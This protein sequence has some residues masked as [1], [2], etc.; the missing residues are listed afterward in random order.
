MRILLLLL[1]L[2]Q[3]GQALA[4]AALLETSPEDGVAL[5]AAPD[6]VRLRFDEPVGLIALG[7][8]GPQ[9]A[10]A[11]A[12][13]RG[14][15]D[16]LTARLPPGLPRGTY[17]LSWRV[18]SVDSHPVAGT[19]AFGIG[20]AP[21]AGHAGGAMPQAFWLLPSMGLRTLFLATLLVA[22]GGALFRLVTEPPAAIR[23]GLAWLAWAGVGL[24]GLQIGVR[25]ALLADAPDLMASAPWTLGAGTTL[26]LSLGVSAAGLAGCALSARAPPGWG[27]AAAL[28]ALAGLPLSGHA[29]TADPR[30][31]TAPALLLHAL[32]AALWLGAFW[33]LLGVLRG[34]G[35]VSALRRFSAM[36]VPAVAVLLLSGL[37]LAVVQVGSM[38][39][40]SDSAYG[41]WLQM[42]ATLVSVL[43][44]LAAWNKLVATPALEAGGPPHVLRRSIAI[45]AALGL[46]VL[47]V[48]AVLG[49]TP[50]PRA[51]PR[52]TD[53][54]LWTQA[55]G[56]G[57]LIE[58]APARVGVNR[59]AVTIDRAKPPL[60]V[61]LELRQPAAGVA[62]LRRKMTLDEG[63]W[64][65]T[66]PEIAAPGRWTIRIEALLTAFDQTT[67][68]T[69]LDIP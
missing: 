21:M 54:A 12:Q 5:P 48:T 32:G 18:T 42:K 34:G 68:T 53:K 69:E 47:A 63:R 6:T 52:P 19:I 25:G 15:G 51:A 41:R 49:L 59:I 39:M 7:L 20:A 44:A 40:L 16:L 61:W 56:I 9:G 31:L 13:T 66:G 30:W 50:P 23:A 10:V 36:A 62:S 11:L 58:V 64:V 26:A 29:G 43:L 3:P 46:A 4:H 45:E 2:W 28:L 14:D 57:A 60:E 17:L 8:V 22:A 37:T 27:V 65:Q 24:A 55:D 1:L 35:A 67:F 33:P 38:A